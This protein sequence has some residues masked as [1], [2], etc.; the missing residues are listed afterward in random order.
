MAK[1]NS[2]HTSY[3]YK[4][5]TSELVKKFKKQKRKICFLTEEDLEKELKETEEEIKKYNNTGY[6]NVLEHYKP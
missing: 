4:I 6:I 1:S 5:K 3:G 2:H